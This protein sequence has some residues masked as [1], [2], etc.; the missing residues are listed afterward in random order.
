[1]TDHIRWMQEIGSEDLA[2]VGAEGSLLG[3]FL[4]EEF[5]VLP[6]FV[7][8][9][10]AL[11]AY[12]E[13]NG[14]REKALAAWTGWNGRTADERRARLA[15]F[16][17]AF[18]APAVGPSLEEDVRQAVLRM[19]EEAGEAAPPPLS[20]R[21]V[22]LPELPG[23]PA[24]PDG[25][26]RLVNLREDVP[27]GSWMREGW[28]SA[29][30][31][32][33]FEACVVS[34]VDPL[35]LRVALVVQRYVAPRVA[36]VT[37]PVFRAGA[38]K[39][40]RVI[41]ACWGRG[42]AVASGRFDVDRFV[43]QCD[44]LVLIE[45]NV[46]SKE[47]RIVAR[48]DGR[49]GIEEAAVPEDLAEMP[50]LTWDQIQDIADTGRAMELFAGRPLVL[51]WAFE[52]GDLWILR[53]NGSAED[54]GRA[55]ALEEP[56]RPDGDPPATEADAPEAATGD[57]RAGESARGEAPDAGQDEAEFAVRRQG[58]AA[59]GADGPG[60]AASGFSPEATPPA[61]E[62]GDGAAAGAASTDASGWDGPAPA[63]PVD[64]FPGWRIG[65]SHRTRARA[66][67]SL[68]DSARRLRGQGGAIRERDEFSHR[69]T[70]SRYWNESYYFNFSDPGKR[71]GGFSRIG[72]V[73]NQ[74]LAIGILYLFLPDGGILMLTQTEP[75]R[76]SRD[77]VAAGL[78]RYE[79][80]EP[81]WSWRIRFQG[82]ML[83]VPDPADLPALVTASPEEMAGRR[84]AFQEASVDLH[85]RGWSPCHNFKDADPRFIAERLVTRGSRLRDLQSVTRVASEHYEQV[86]AWTGEIVLD[87]RRIPVAG[88]G[89]RDHSW[90]DRDWKAVQTWTWI[91]AQFGDAFGFN[92]SRVVIRSLDLFNGYVCR[93][94]RNYPLRRAWLDTEFEADGRTQKRVL[95]RLQDTAGWEAEIVGRPRIVVPLLLQ[96]DAHRTLV[97]EALTKAESA[98]KHATDVETQA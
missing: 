26:E 25:W 17:S 23:L 96:E 31:E 34:G 1:M 46:E 57:A 2:A 81:L 37:S 19:Q 64:R 69:H 89:H 92:L 54:P 21:P 55:E 45:Q 38:A 12:L 4:R 61:R 33:V 13:E 11:D 58:P 77:T 86:G 72:M 7:I 27:P 73:P 43:L 88:S 80:T 44:P 98:R 29:W 52:E 50:S 49:S 95:L 28:G 94:G 30:S 48:A 51:H 84:L 91:T 9:P 22:L 41:D 42:E 85:F 78:L 90:G 59:G 66:L 56:P 20:V 32:A 47:R 71:I 87:G 67:A 70:D 97:N 35:S 8:L 93:S 6:G 63:F 14:L 39:R 24:L 65:W 15:D 60:A 75:C 79:R 68:F 18:L 74:D 76:A 53:A 62:T 5:P 83:H 10:S 16:R 40:E 82:T 3:R 36:G